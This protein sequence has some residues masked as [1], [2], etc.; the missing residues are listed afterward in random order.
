MFL[1]EQTE[2]TEEIINYINSKTKKNFSIRAIIREE[3]GENYNKTDVERLRKSISKKITKSGFS[4]DKERKIYIKKDEITSNNISNNSDKN[5]DSNTLEFEI[6]KDKIK[7][8]D[9]NKI[10]DI[11][12]KN[13][14]KYV[15]QIDK[16]LTSNPLYYDVKLENILLSIDYMSQEMKDNELALGI[17][18]E[19]SA[20]ELFSLILNRFDYINQYQLI[21]LAIHSVAK[22]KHTLSNSNW[23]MEYSN[24][25]LTNKTTTKKKQM[26]FKGYLKTRDMI[27]LI[28]AEFPLLKRSDIPSFCLYIFTKCYEDVQNENN[29]N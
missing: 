10:Q 20:L 22:H 23:L 11:N 28:Q 15:K 25:I 9:D 26:T 29:N 4:F 27:N 13:K 17:M 6:K 3:L 16:K 7:N 21:Q 18:L 1:T 2:I 8:L 12:K 24:F 19:P 5:K 14:R